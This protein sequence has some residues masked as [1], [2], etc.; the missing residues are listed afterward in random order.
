[1]DRD[2]IL[3][4]LDRNR[5]YQAF[6]AFVALDEAPAPVAL[7]EPSTPGWFLPRCSPLL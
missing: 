7:A 4:E 5:I 1:M 2:R 3:M 6:L